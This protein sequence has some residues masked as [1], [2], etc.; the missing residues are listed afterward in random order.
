MFLVI[1]AVLALTLT[2]PHALHQTGNSEPDTTI[3]SAI[4]AR[5]IQGVL[6]RLEEG[7]EPPAMRSTLIAQPEVAG[8]PSY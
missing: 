2:V 3:D 5:V 8:L 4:R 6:R 1:S 7:Y